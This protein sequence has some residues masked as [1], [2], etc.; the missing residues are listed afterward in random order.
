MIP[1][2]DGKGR[3]AAFEV[4][5]SVS[6]VHNLIRENKTYQINTVIQTGSNIGMIG[7]DQSLMGLVNSGMIAPSEARRW[8][9]EPKM[10]VDRPAQAVSA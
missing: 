4:L 3:I 8:A 6:A 5:I 1:K 9:S 7:M 2:K 10:F